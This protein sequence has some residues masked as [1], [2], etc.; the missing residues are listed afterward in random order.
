MPSQSWAMKGRVPLLETQPVS[1][2]REKKILRFLVLFESPW[3][4]AKRVLNLTPFS[5]K[6]YLFGVCFVLDPGP[7]KRPG[8]SADQL[9]ALR[10]TNGSWNMAR[11][12]HTKSDS[13]EYQ[14]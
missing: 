14:T 3:N 1:R 5:L 8:F 12:Q 4:A 2:A 13:R 10:N 9:K 11:K 7:W 6:F